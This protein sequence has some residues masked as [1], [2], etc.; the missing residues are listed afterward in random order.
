MLTLELG[1]TSDEFT[2]ALD[3]GRGVQKYTMYK[4]KR[5]GEIVN[6]V[7]VMEYGVVV[8]RGY[9]GTNPRGMQAG[10]ILEFFDVPE[11]EKKGPEGHVCSIRHILYG[12]GFHIIRISEDTLGDKVYPRVMQSIGICRGC[13]QCYKVAQYTRP[14]VLKERMKRCTNQEYADLL[15]EKFHKMRKRD[16]DRYAIESFEDARKMLTKQESSEK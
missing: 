2:L 6:V 5:T 12:P 3:K 1:C 14:G 9:R 10:D 7:N 4:N 15:R 16:P 11:E 8:N 13:G